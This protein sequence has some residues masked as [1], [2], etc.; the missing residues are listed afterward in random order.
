MLLMLPAR[1]GTGQFSIQDGFSVLRNSKASC[2][3]PTGSAFPAFVMC[4]MLLLFSLTFSSASAVGMP[5]LSGRIN[6]YAAM[7]SPEARRLIETKLDSLEQAESTQIVI[8]TVPSLEGEP[9]E[10]FSIR[11]AEAWKIGQKQFDNGVLLIV[12]K[13]DRKMRIEVGYGLEG[14]LTDLQ[15]GRII[16]YAIAP[17]FRAGQTDQGFISGVDALIEAV[18]GEYKAPVKK[19]KEDDGSLFIAMLIIIILFIYFSRQV[20]KSLGGAGPLIFGGG[21][22]QGGGFHNGG[23]FGGGGGGFGGGGASGD[24]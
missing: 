23:G 15:S 3:Y 4:S 1:C 14:R 10:D 2:R 22:W 17:Y 18:S 7:I 13:N 21:P 11:V 6:D 5:K 19:E 20:P 16:D 9:I 12:S 8:L 24:W